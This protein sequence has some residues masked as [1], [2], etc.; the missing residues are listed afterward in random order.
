MLKTEISVAQ[1]IKNPG[2]ETVAELDFCPE[3]L[4]LCGR[5]LVPDG[6][7]HLEISY[8]YDGEGGINTKGTV[9]GSFSEQCARCGIP[10]SYGL[11]CDFTERF[12]KQN[13]GTEQDA[14]DDS[15]CFTGDSIDLTDFL[16]EIILLN[17]PMTVLCRDDCEGLCPVC[18]QNL[19]EGRC[20]CNTEPEDIDPNDENAFEKALERLKNKFTVN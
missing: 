9:T 15:Y 20:S 16:N 17:Y 6:N 1:E 11:K 14:E 18:G 5:K 4:E 2:R 10:V 3:D 12:I 19:N 8:S 13:T 7:M